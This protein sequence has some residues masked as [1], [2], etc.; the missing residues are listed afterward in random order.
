[1]LRED[2]LPH[3]EDL[4]ITSVQAT[5][6]VRMFRPGESSYCPTVAELVA[7]FAGSSGAVKWFT[8][9][10]AMLAAPSSSWS[11]AKTLHS[12]GTDGVRSAWSRLLKSDPVASGV[13]AREDDILETTDGLAFAIR[14][15]L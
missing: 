2:E 10:S 6:R 7:S 4:T 15:T 8:S 5:D 13:V 1:M 3:V 12:Y 9:I 11:A 14:D